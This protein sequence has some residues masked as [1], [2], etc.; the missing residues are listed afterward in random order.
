MKRVFAH[1]G[2]AV[3]REVPEPTL[4]RGE[5]L[6][7]PAFSAISAGTET[8][9]IDGSADPDFGVHEYPSVPP[10]WPKTRT[11]VNLD[12]PMPKPSDP[13]YIGIG[14]SLAGVVV[15]VDDQVTDIAVGDLVA[16]SGSQCAH[17]AE[18]VSVPRHLVARVPPGLPLDQAAFVT[19]G[20]ISMAALRETQCHFGETVVQFG[21]GLLGLLGVQIGEA[22]GLTTIGIDIDPSR[23]R[24][25]V[26]LGARHVLDPTANDVAAA[27]KE[28]TDGYGA[29]GVILGIKSESSE[30]LNQ[31]FDMSRQR[32]R[33]VGLGVFGWDI[34]RGRF[35]ANR[36]SLHPA[37][38]YGLGRYDPV[39]EE[40]NVDYPIGLA[41]WT[42]NRNQEYFLDLLARGRVDVRPLAPD[43][44]PI[45]HASEAYDILRGADRPPT[46]LL[47]YGSGT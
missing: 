44:I 40:G 45:E 4:R 36:V 26:E 9:L 33:V 34:D 35:F 39:Y 20:S 41:R 42:E 30:P 37:V 27:V 13:A 23:R 31:C 3:V 6:V 2:K 16:C 46:V 12:H 8:W 1:G 11:P 28:L 10:Y 43:R 14:Y 17:H 24:L 15:D 25:A 22:A 47:E 38:G 18:L 32:G 7:K 5:V 19:L 21:L 29:D